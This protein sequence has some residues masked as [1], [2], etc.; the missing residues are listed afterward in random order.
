[1]KSWLLPMNEDGLL[2]DQSA[3]ARICSLHVA[4]M[5]GKEHF[6][7]MRD[8]RNLINK[9]SAA[10][11]EDASTSIDQHTI[12]YADRN[13]QTSI[14]NYETGIQNKTMGQ[15]ANNRCDASRIESGT[16]KENESSA[17][18]QPSNLNADKNL[19]I[20]ISNYFKRTTYTN[21]NNQ[22]Y[23]CYVMTLDGF[24]LLT[25]GYTGEKASIIKLHILGAFK[26]MNEA[27]QARL[28]LGKGFRALC[29][30]IHSVNPDANF[31]HFTN[32]ADMINRIV[33]GCTAKAYRD[34]HGIDENESLRKYL[35]DWEWKSIKSLQLA[36]SAFI[37][38][39]YP[40]MKRKSELIAYYAGLQKLNEHK[41]I[42]KDEKHIEEK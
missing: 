33:I 21:P 4:E 18:K 3:T 17:T 36:D 29:N 40:Y 27:I 26:K 22:K 13:F 6:I 38:M 24:M 39:G 28:E 37:V 20:D 5:F 35:T 15:G 10:T 8:I 23:N 12:L 32:E 31:Y 14:L 41:L 2:G 30:A 7:V 1:M 34:E 11:K 9:Y 42:L 19:Q 25:M 16:T